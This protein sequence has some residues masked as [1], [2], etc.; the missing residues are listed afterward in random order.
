MVRKITFKNKQEW[1]AHKDAGFKISSSNIGIICGLSEYISPYAYWKAVK[2]N[3]TKA[4]NEH[5]RRGIL[6]E[7]AI[8]KYFEEVS[9]EKVVKNTSN[10]YVLRNDNF[11]DY[12]EVSPDREL[13]KNG[14]KSRLF[15][16]IKDTKR[17]I[18][19]KNNDDV[20][21]EWYAQIQLQMYVGE[22][23][24]C[25]LCVYGG[26]KMIDFRYFDL[27]T[28]F[29]ESALKYAIEWAERY[30]FG[31]EEPELSTKD[32]V[33]E[34]YLKPE[35]NSVANAEDSFASVIEAYNSVNYQIGVLERSREEIKNKIAVKIADKEILNIGG[36]DCATFK[37]QKKGSVDTEKLKSEYPDVYNAC[38]KES[39]FRVLKIKRIKK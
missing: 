30:I 26:D 5:T 34:K 8:A 37:Y 39:E 12:I 36:I 6:F 27:D 23:E 1:E 33:I 29:I 16:E 25:I 2:T 18:D 24:H 20:P 31:E 35:N 10:Y 32:D 9:T 13:F 19:L 3:T 4:Q 17:T 11:P 14:R 15:L 38:I 22:Y 21:K 7:D 28:E